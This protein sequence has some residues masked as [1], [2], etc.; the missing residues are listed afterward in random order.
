MQPDAVGSVVVEVARKRVHRHAVRHLELEV[1]VG[2]DAAAVGG[3]RVGDE[4]P[5]LCR[6]V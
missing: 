2:D 5:A 4:E 6:P 3:E 1:E